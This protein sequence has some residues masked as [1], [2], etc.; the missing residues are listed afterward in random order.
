MRRPAG[1]A[2]K[3]AGALQVFKGIPYA[4]A[5]DRRAALEAAGC[6]CRMEGHARRHG[7]RPG[8]HP[9]QA[10]GRAAST[11]G[12][13]P[14]PAR[15][16]CRS[17]SGRPPRR[18]NAPVFVW[19]HGGALAA[20]PAAT[21]CTTAPRLADAR[22]R[23][24]HDQLSPRACSAISR[25]PRSAPSRREHVSG[26]YGLLDQIEALRWV[27]RNIAAFGGDPANVTIAGESAGGLSV[28][29]LMAAPDARGLFAKAI[30][31][32]AY[33]ISTPELRSTTFGDFTAEAIGEWVAGKVGA[34]DLA[35]LRA[36][37]ATRSRPTA[38][39]AGYTPL[40]HGRWAR[41]AAAARRRVRS[42]RAGQGADARRLQQRRDPFAAFPAAAGAGR[43]G[44]L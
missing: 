38:A 18:G 43:R 22:R 27:K 20:G 6:R 19:I 14:R 35:G 37:D 17:T 23:R 33:M 28:M 4:L 3:L 31:Q 40:R 12:T 5:A 21:G 44:D 34:T 32:S 8:V 15:T 25:I 2:A 36:M 13:C 9:A 24:R 29:Y 26:N 1:C 16:A 7:I 41:P 11:R 30:A 39:T 42:R 10:A